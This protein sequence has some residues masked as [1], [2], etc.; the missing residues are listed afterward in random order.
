MKPKQINDLLINPLVLRKNNYKSYSN[1]FIKEEGYMSSF[2]KKFENEVGN[3]FF[4]NF[5]FYDMQNLSEKMPIEP[6]C[7]TAHMQLKTLEDMTVNVSIGFEKNKSLEEIENWAI[8]LF[9]KMNFKYED[10]LYSSSFKEHKAQSQQ[11]LLEETI[12]K[13][14]SPVVKIKI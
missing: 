2:Q 7:W 10:Y 12:E 14:S 5:E 1:S 6:Y 3:M 8:L 9:K 13:K 11:Q 4:L